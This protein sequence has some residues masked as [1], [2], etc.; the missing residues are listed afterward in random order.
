MILNIRR[1]NRVVEIPVIQIRPSRT[2]SRK[3]YN[4]EKLQELANSIRNNGLLQPVMVR[5]IT[6]MEYE[7][8]AGER[9]L[10]ACIICGKTR[11]PCIVISCSDDEAKIFSIE[12]NMQRTNLNFIEEAQCVN[13]YMLSENISQN[14][15]ADDLSLQPADISD[16]MDVLRLDEQERELV[17]K[18]HL[19]I[20][21]A[22][23]LLKIQDKLERRIVLSEIIENS[24]NVSQTESYINEILYSTN[25]ER[26]RSQRRKGV[27][28]D[29][30]MFENTIKKAISALNTSGIDASAEYYEDESCLEYTIRIPKE[31]P[32]TDEFAA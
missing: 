2:Q 20:K 17:L 4:K 3:S 6:S 16:M 24:M 27:L 30:K 12:E 1:S 18:Y 32:V 13:S 10:R 5:R 29:V 7:L 26:L 9:R 28:R 15:A 22:K 23:A 14:E 19:S 11:I 21:H 8:I 31:H 25:L